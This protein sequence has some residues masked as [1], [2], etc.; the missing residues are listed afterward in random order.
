MAILSKAMAFIYAGENERPVNVVNFRNKC[1]GGLGLFHPV[2]KAKALL[3]KNMYKELLSLK[4]GVYDMDKIDQV[5]GYREDFINIINNGLSTSPSK[6]IYD[7]MLK[8]ITHRNESLIP[9][10]NEKRSSNV[11]WGIVF[12]N[13][14][15]MSGLTAEE[16][17]FAWKISQ[18][19]LPTGSRIHRRNAERRCL[20]PL[21][22]AT[23]CQEIQDLEHVFRS[24]DTVTESYDM[25]IQALNRFTD[26][27]I[28]YNLLVHFAFNH[29][30]KR[31]LKCALWFAVKMMFAIFH[32]KVLNKRQLLANMIKE[33]E[34]NLEL[35]RKIGSQGEMKILK[36]L[37]LDIR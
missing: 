4:G 26:R 31:K 27:N 11:K 29:R 37:L 17:C 2:I 13:M 1:E 36:A 9:S 19:M 16:K 23:L 5:Y 14:K 7:F 22:D 3:V 28:S 34:W 10:R 6:A 12:K 15:L 35:N 20:V 25:I 21:G 30:N 18:D 8:E 33:I 24:C 32:K